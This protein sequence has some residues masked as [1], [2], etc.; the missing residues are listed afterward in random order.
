MHH[1]LPFFMKE[2][3]KMAFFGHKLCLLAADKQLKIPPLFG[4]GWMR[5][6]T[7]QSHKVPKTSICS[8]HMHQN[9]S[10]FVEQTAKNGLFLVK[11]GVF[12]DSDKQLKTPSLF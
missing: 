6:S 2:W 5:E 12:L 8:M 7:F 4:G 3:P 11:N 10:F 1:S 9:L